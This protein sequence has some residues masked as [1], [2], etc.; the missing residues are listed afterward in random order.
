MAEVT[1]RVYGMW[2]PTYQ[3]YLYMKEFQEQYGV[4]MTRREMAAAMG[5]ASLTASVGH[6]R[7]LMEAGMVEKHKFIGRRG[8]TYLVTEIT[9]RIRRPRY[10]TARPTLEPIS[11]NELADVE[12][13]DDGEE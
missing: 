3:L 6:L 5:W 12:S 2:T 8:H 9:R 11:P 7:K 1:K 4:A 13:D 10:G